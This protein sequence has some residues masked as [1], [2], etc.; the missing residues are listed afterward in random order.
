[1]E[2]IT[3]RGLAPLP[4]LVS[5][6]GATTWTLGVP[7]VA[8]ALLRLV[9]NPTP[10]AAGVVIVVASVLGALTASLWGR[11]RGGGGPA[12][13]SDL[14]LW[15]WF[16]RLQ[17]YRTIEQGEEL[18]VE[19]DTGQQVDLD[20]LQSLAGALEI[21][22]PYTH[23][24]SKRV[25]RLVHRTAVMLADGLSERQ[26][27]LL[28]RAAVL[29]DIGKM[30]VPDGVL[31]KSGPLTADE[32]V[33]MQQHVVVGARLVS[34]VGEPTITE[35]V[36]HHHEAWDGSG[37]PLG[38][39][40][41]DIPLF[42]RIISVAD[43]YDAMVSARPYR[44]SLGRTSAIATLKREAGRQFDPRVVKS[45]IS[46]LPA[47][48][49]VRIMVPIFGLLGRIGQD[50]LTWGRRSGIT[51]LGPTVGSGAAAAVL[52]TALLI[53]PPGGAGWVEGGD[54]QGRTIGPVLELDASVPRVATTRGGE[55]VGRRSTRAPADGAGAV[56]SRSSEA[57][58]GST[59]ADEPADGD[60]SDGAQ[61]GG[62]GSGGGGVPDGSGDNDG[63]D[64][65][66]D[67][68]TP[69][70]PGQ[71]EPPQGPPGQGEP[72]QAPGGEEP[73]GGGGSDPDGGEGTPGDP[74]PD[75][76]KDCERPPPSPGNDKHCGG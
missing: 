39:A 37:Y 33:L 65:G 61:S 38:L 30:H 6:V 68:P 74:Q 60:V 40:G 48:A 26:I 3:T 46:I 55:R 20:L 63:P 29:H 35:A 23:G 10:A 66:P 2:K 16:R 58:P 53:T 15:S 69:D 14:L 72:P 22:D 7:I 25:E 1:L 45:L 34:K 17:A 54:R 64:P 67:P 73:G 4:P 12:T 47:P 28:R 62:P 9:G 18:L 75:M 49:R 27:D 51:T 19:T 8:F 5:A 44:A 24:H 50:A 31:R 71:G 70:P 56:P 59:T 41:Q 57:A 52:S 43:A 42:A 36:L 32:W 13:L 21:L 11:T 76:G